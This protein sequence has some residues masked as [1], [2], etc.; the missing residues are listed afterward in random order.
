[1]AEQRGGVNNEIGSVHRRGIAVF[2]AAYGLAGEGLLGG[3]FVPVHLAFETKQATDDLCCVSEAGA[4]MFISAKHTCGNDEQNFGATVKQWVKQ[5]AA[6]APDDLLVLATAELRGDLKKL[7]TALDRRRQAPGTPALR[8]EQKALAALERKIDA[9]TDDPVVRERIIEA[10]HVLVVNVVKA[11][12]IDFDLGVALL[13]GSV[14]AK[15]HGR[16]AVKALAEYFHTQASTAFASNLDDWVKVLRETPIEVF[17]DGEGA[18]GA[19]ANARHLALCAY[20]DWLG[21]E[22]G[23]VSMSLLSEEL[24]ELIVADLADGL[25]VAVEGGG[26]RRERVSLLAMTRRWP[27]L[28]LAGLPGMGKSTALSQLAARWAKTPTAALPVQVSLPVV[29]GRCGRASDVTLGLLCEVA[30]QYAPVEHRKVLMASLERACHTGHAVL[31]LDG[32]DECG[33]RRT[34]IADG[35]QRM[36]VELPAGLGIVLSTRD[37]GLAAA[38]KLGLAQVAL[39]TP[40][41]LGTVMHRLLQHVADTHPLDETNRER[42]VELRRSWLDAARQ[43]HPDIADVPL[44]ATMMTLVVAKSAT[45][46]VTH[47]QAQLLKTAVQE[48]VRDWEHHRGGSIATRPGLPTAQQLIDGFTAIGSRLM[49]S[50]AASRV[51]VRQAIAAMLAN[52]WDI[53]AVGPAGEL[54][55]HILQ[56][57]DQ[58]LGVFVDAGDGT[59]RPRSRVFAELAAAMAVQWLA[60]TPLQEWVNT[61]VGDLDR[62]VTLALAAELHPKVLNILLRD[63]REPGFA[64]RAL[65]AAN[66]LRRAVD[67]SNDQLHVLVTL[68]ADAAAQHRHL[69]PD[70]AASGWRCTVAL[71]EL[72]L[73]T[74]LRTTREQALERLCTD[75]QQRVI[76]TA[77][78]A[79]SDA[80]VDGTALC[81]PQVAN[82]RA[83]LQRPLPTRRISDVATDVHLDLDAFERSLPGHLQV[84]AASI[85]HLK[86]LGSDMVN[87]VHELAEL[88]TFETYS[89]LVQALE[90]AGY[91]V[92]TPSWRKTI[93]AMV[94]DAL[95]GL[96]WDERQMP[97]LESAA[98]FAEPGVELSAQQ[99]WRLP[100]LACLFSLVYLPKVTIGGIRA[101]FAPGQAP[102]RTEWLRALAVAAGLDLALLAAQAQAAIAEL[103]DPAAT[104]VIDF[105]E[106]PA[107]GRMPAWDA[108]RLGERERSALLAAM[109]SDSEW[110][111]QSANQ[112]LQNG[113]ANA[114]V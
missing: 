62:G 10:A 112:V 36:L 68:L 60:D 91:D 28:L 32:F 102:T 23:R 86:A 84:A 87:R 26:R 3:N 34:W 95:P 44:L 69:D 5:A 71:A 82:V 14:V 63:E 56:F 52:Q 72:S 76:V 50:G 85:P 45:I 81:P 40:D 105:L 33:P 20:R 13:Q 46:P 67:T 39:V 49:D 101:A 83:A 53:R 15:G 16:A 22:E 18:A 30:A 29:A 55:T 35:L 59:V 90:D 6:L 17:A 75:D 108:S 98:Q 24:P 64:T 43:A 114:V 4:R 74:A 77:L 38:R 96:A 79:L 66:V 109:T 2:L 11:G 8:S 73:P 7:P 9:C 1:M 93:N 89:D 100:E 111:A 106:M 31:L 107:A 88:A 94:A 41:K 104:R 21:A 78:V 37:S 99:R 12:D 61:A 47:G 42:W 103:N 25:R 92:P 97:L 65:L 51:Q 27:R 113:T 80:A 19:A 110:M 54:T 58:H 57:W 70:A 48:S